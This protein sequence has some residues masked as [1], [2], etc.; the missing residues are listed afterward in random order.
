LW[1]LAPLALVGA[2]TWAAALSQPDG[3]LHATFL[4]AGQGD[5]TLVKTPSG[6]LVV[7]DGGPNP[8][9]INDAVSRSLPFCQRDIALAVL[10]RAT[11]EK[12]AG[13]AS[14]LER[15]HVAQLAAPGTL[16]RSATAQRWR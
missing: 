9:S 7:I 10:T 12:M 13:L 4:D 15:H 1:P 5:A 14:L 16:P 3:R 6:Q 2:L 11:D 8:T